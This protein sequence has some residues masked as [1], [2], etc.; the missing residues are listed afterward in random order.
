MEYKR[1]G[2]YGISSTGKTT[3]AKLIGKIHPQYKFI[4]GSDVFNKVCSG[5]LSAFKKLSFEN[6]TQYRH[7][8]IEYLTKLQESLKQH[9]VIAGHYSF[10][11]KNNNYEI[12][13]TKA[14]EKFYSDIF[15]FT[16]TAKNIF[17]RNSQ[18]NINLSIEEINNWQKFEINNIK[19]LTNQ[20]VF[21]INETVIKKM[22][23]SV[24]EKINKNLILDELTKII[25]KKDY[26]TYILFD[27]DGTLIPFDSS[28]LI[29]KYINNSTPQ[30]IK[31][32]FKKYDNYCFE[33]FFDV[34]THYSKTNKLE[35]WENAMFKA[36]TEI[37]LNQEFIQ[38]LE[39]NSVGKI[40]LSA[41]F[42]NL[43]KYVVNKYKFSN[44]HVI[45]GNSL[46]DKYIISDKNKG[47]IV[48]F[49]KS[50]QRKVFSFGDSL[51]DKQML[52][53]SD[54]GIYVVYDRIKSVYKYLLDKKNIRCLSF[55]QKLQPK[56]CIKTDIPQIITLLN[57]D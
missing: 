15:I 52:L 33:A 45:A 51:V 48:D 9:F 34:A 41:G 14:D 30:I 19:K 21:V 4:D 10:F 47:D 55:N 3:V 6:K 57:L 20:N 8:A 50:N 32:I 46:Y 53:K 16:D 24:L 2:L 5:G 1:I 17:K 26:N 13:W 43:W 38:L 39:N 44:I 37:E 36:S 35:I 42:S 22:A 18:R 49:L 23:F 12:A 40:I 31:Q 7:L 56:D 54:L 27:A 28:L 29:T 11:S 25:T